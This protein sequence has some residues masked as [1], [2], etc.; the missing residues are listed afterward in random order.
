[1]LVPV[2]AI[3][4]VNLIHP[5]DY[6]YEHGLRR[7]TGPSR[8]LEWGSETVINLRQQL[9]GYAFLVGDER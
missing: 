7:L 9:K 4:A 2:A 8:S 5:F 6:L 1:V 3:G